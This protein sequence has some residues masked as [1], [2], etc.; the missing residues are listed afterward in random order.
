MGGPLL[1]YRLSTLLGRR[2]TKREYKRGEAPLRNKF[3]LPLVKG[4]G[5]KGIG[6]LTGD[7]VLNRG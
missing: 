2:D 3:P 4:K 5:I 6:F 7:R 1:N